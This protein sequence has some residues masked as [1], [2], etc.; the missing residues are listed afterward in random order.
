[1]MDALQDII[2][3]ESGFETRRYQSPS[4]SAT[5]LL[6][7]LFSGLR[8]NMGAALRSAIMA[9]AQEHRLGYTQISDT[10]EPYPFKETS[11]SIFGSRGAIYVIYAILC[12][13]I[14]PIQSQVGQ[15]GRNGFHYLYKGKFS[16]TTRCRQNRG[17]AAY[18]CKDILLM[19]VDAHP[20]EV[21]YS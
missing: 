13:L 20:I 15:T 21:R 5:S 8:L 14:S 6:I 1:M 2:S 19:T 7:F 18:L 16:S 4:Q 10:R 17:S 11:I 12:W 3:F 9:I